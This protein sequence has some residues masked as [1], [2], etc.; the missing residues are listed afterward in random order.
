MSRTGRPIAPGVKRLMDVAG[1]GGAV[2]VLAPV[3]AAV[4]AVVRRKIGHPV[5]FTQM[6]PGKGGKPF[7]IYKF[8]TMTDRAGW[9]RP[10][11]S[12]C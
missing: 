3:M 5:I 1:A 2:L 12:R 10:T 11:P 8:R 9:K 7:R 4:A 6:R